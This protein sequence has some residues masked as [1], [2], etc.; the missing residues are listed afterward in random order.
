MDEFLEPKQITEGMKQ[1]LARMYADA[2]MREYL[3]NAIAIYK[4]AAIKLIETKDID[5]AQACASRAAAYTQLLA[6]GKQ[7][8]V[9]FDK[10]RKGSIL[11]TVEEVKL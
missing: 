11:S 3:N 9:H 6:R 5:K 10:L 1:G 4:N 7:H 8:F 2:F